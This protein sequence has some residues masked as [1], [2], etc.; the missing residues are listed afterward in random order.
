MPVCFHFPGR[1]CLWVL[2]MPR[3]SA[4]SGAAWAEGSGRVRQRQAAA[5]WQACPSAQAGCAAGVSRAKLGS[6]PHCSAPCHDRSARHSK[7]QR[8]AQHAQRGASP[9][10][11]DVG[12]Q[13]LRGGQ[14]RS[15]GL[16]NRLLY[17]LLDTLHTRAGGAGRGGERALAV[18][19][20]WQGEWCG[21]TPTLQPR[22]TTCQASM[23]IK[24]PNGG[25]A[26]SC[27]SSQLPSCQT[28]GGRRRP[29]ASPAQC[30]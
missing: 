15:L 4:P 25:P 3:I 16:R 27:T 24:H 10:F 12:P 2:S 7:A 20:G 1:R 11:V 14:W 30:P 17:L 8:T 19:E 26:A 18:S 29:V 22:C 5:Y 13:L 21:L 23:M 9:T 28:G 6:A